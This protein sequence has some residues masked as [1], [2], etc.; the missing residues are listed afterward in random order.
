MKLLTF[1]DATDNDPRILE[2]RAD[3]SGPLGLIAADWFTTIRQ[4][5][6][7]IT[8]ILHDGYPTACVDVYP[9]AYVGVFKAHVNVGFFYGAELDDP[10]NLLEGTGKR[11]RH[12][13]IRADEEVKSQTLE[14]LI[15]SAYHDIQQRI[16]RLNSSSEA[17]Q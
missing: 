3:H 12:V 6:A 9:F 14:S 13:K 5:G 15:A 17:D 7:N 2:W 8:E 10:A 11:M 1:T 4:R 16:D